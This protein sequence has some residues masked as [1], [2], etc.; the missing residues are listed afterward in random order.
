MLIPNHLEKSLNSKQILTL[1][2][3]KNNGWE[4]CFIR[5]D[6]LDGPV[7]VIKNERSKNIGV[8]DKDGN[9]NTNPS[10]SV[11]KS[12]REPERGYG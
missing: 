2:K 7:P 12:P 1:R 4:L 3:L 10:I 11:R 6:G 5:R 9:L 8:I